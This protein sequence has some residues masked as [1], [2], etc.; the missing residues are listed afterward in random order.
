[1]TTTTKPANISDMQDAA[2]ARWLSETLEPAR[3]RVRQ[4]PTA[5]AVARIRERLFGEG[6]ARKKER[7]IAA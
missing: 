7:R 2:V 1:M 4:T 5:S 6:A 3:A